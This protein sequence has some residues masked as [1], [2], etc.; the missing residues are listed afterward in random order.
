MRAAVR[1]QPRAR[2]TAFVLIAGLLTAFALLFAPP[3]TVAYD[4]FHES[5]GSFEELLVAIVRDR[6]FIERRK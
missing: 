3:A 1:T 6:S 5:Q 2:A 4:A